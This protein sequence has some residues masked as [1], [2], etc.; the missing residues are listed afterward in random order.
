MR[1]NKRS[2][3]DLAGDRD[4]EYELTAPRR[5]IQYRDARASGGAVAIGLAAVALVAHIYDRSTRHTPAPP[6]ASTGTAANAAA[7]PGAAGRLG[8]VEAIPQKVFHASPYNDWPLFE[9]H[10]HEGQRLKFHRENGSWAGDS[11]CLF[12]QFETPADIQARNEDATIADLE[13]KAAN[14]ARNVLGDDMRKDL[15]AARIRE[16]NARQQLDRIDRLH[17]RTAATQADHDRARNALALSRTQREQLERLLERKVE[18]AGVQVEVADHKA[19][20]AESER[21][22]AEFKRE[23]SW[24]RVP[25]ARGRF[26]EVVVTKIQAVR[27]DTQGQGGK[28]D[29]W[30]E[31]V[32]DRTLQVRVF[33]AVQQA[34]RL[35]PGGVATVRQGARRYRGEILS[36]GALADKATHLIPVLVKVGNDDRLLRIHT[37]VDVDFPGPDG[38]R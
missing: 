33:L 1:S 6:P 28:K 24:G 15:E 31:V 26:E 4:D 23:M 5:D 13:L 20:R 34:E 17:E 21:Q 18:V 11:T 25:V 22:L 32:D 8:I 37:E 19:R 30:V 29:V 38:A 16:E 14:L 10:V 27:G 2:V 3:P 12:V 35:A 7:S 36:I 9:L